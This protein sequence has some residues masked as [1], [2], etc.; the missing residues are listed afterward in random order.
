MDTCSLPPSAIAL[1]TKDH[2]NPIFCRF[3]YEVSF[4]IFPQW[5]NSAS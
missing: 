4:H 1:V 3:A 2:A 5:I